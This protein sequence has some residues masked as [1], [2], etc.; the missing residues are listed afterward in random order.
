MA[1]SER[2][3]AGRVETRTS[4]SMPLP[5]LA[6]AS[7]AARRTF[8]QEINPSGPRGYPRL[9]GDVLGDR[10]PIHQ[11]EILMDEGDGQG[12]DAGAD[13]MPVKD[14]LAGIGRVDPRQDLDQR[15]LARAILAEQRM[16]LARPDVEIHMVESQRAGKALGQARRRR[17]ADRWRSPFQELLGFSHRCSSPPPSSPP[18]PALPNCGP[19]GP[20]FDDGEGRRVRVANSQQRGRCKHRLMMI[21]GRG[22]YPPPQPSPARG[23]GE[24]VGLAYCATP[25]ISR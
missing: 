4:G 17:E 12:I 19:S 16:D 5:M 18:L 9:H 23:E 21:R 10:H 13:G 25:Q 1:T 20:R 24:D 11:A 6:S 7:T 2:S 14:D 22:S 8:A 3:A 15:R